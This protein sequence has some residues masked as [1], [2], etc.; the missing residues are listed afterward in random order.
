[1][2]KQLE[3]KD[4][5][6]EYSK[7]KKKREHCKQPDKWNQSI[8]RMSMFSKVTRKKTDD[9]ENTKTQTPESEIQTVKRKTSQEHAVDKK[10]KHE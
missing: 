10:I 8:I 1:M 5:S 2:Y 4:L 6:K 9:A 7:Y 3:L